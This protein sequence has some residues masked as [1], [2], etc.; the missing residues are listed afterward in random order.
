LENV[1]ELTVLPEGEV[2][3][4][5]VVELDNLSDEMIVFMTKQTFFEF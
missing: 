3:I 5:D 4:V 2:P 1:R